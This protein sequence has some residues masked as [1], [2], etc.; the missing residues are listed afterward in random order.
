MSRNFKKFTAI[1][2]S[3]VYDLR[4]KISNPMT[5]KGFYDF[6]NKSL[7]LCDVRCS[8]VCSNNRLLERKNGLDFVCVV[9]NGET[10]VDLTT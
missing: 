3:D 1:T 2:L 7:S 9:E 4:V 10:L 8:S 5:S 6:M